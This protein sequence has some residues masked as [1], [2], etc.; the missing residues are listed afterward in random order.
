MKDSLL[1]RKF[2][3]AD[4][5]SIRWQVVWPKKFREEFLT[6]AHNGMTTCHMSRQKTAVAIQSRVYWPS[7]SSDLGMFIKRCVPCARYRRG[8]APKQA[9]MRTPKVGEPWERVSVDITGPHPK[10]SRGNVYILTLV[11]HFSKWAEAIPLPNHTAPVVARA[12]M[13][14]VFVRFGVPRQLLS[15]RGPEFESV[16]FGELMKWLQI[17]KLRTTAY[18]PSTNGVVERF[19][20]TL[21]SMLAKV[22]SESQR[23]WD[24]RV[25]FVLAAYRS[26]PHD[27]TGYSPNLLFLGHDTRM[28]I[29][30]LMGLP[31]DQKDPGHTTEDFIVEMQQRAESAYHV[32]RERLQVAAE[33]R[34]ASYDIRVKE[35]TFKEG[36]WVWYWYPRRYLRKSPKWQKCYTGPYLIVRVIPPVNFVLQLSAKS[37]PFVVHTDKLKKCYGETPV[38][39]LNVATEHAAEPTQEAKCGTSRQSYSVQEK[40]RHAAPRFGQF[41][42]IL[43]LSEGELVFDDQV[44]NSRSTSDNGAEHGDDFRVGPLKKRT[45]G[46]PKYLSDYRC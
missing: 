27:S 30:L 16:L 21:N 22:V 37:K 36:D 15:D 13:N 11:D 19:H 4:G 44:P 24:E 9:M 26:S 33:R 3:G 38:S 29:D 25:P 2:E 14:Q 42:T 6:I 34:K 17:D 40:R 10:S 43:P 28:P 20:R 45:R 1:K 5:T 8:S 12:L 31:A 41:N 23:D 7:W 39:W 32:A 46:P 18:K 35:Q